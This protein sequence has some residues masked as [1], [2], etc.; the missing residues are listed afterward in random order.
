MCELS[1]CR[2]HQLMYRIVCMP[3]RPIPLCTVMLLDI[4]VAPG[5]EQPTRAVLKRRVHGLLGTALRGLPE[6]GRMAVES[7]SAAVVCFVGDPEEGLDAAVALRN[8]VEQRYDGKLSVRV[9]LNIGTVHVAMDP[10]NQLQVTGEGIHHA[11]EIKERA[12]PNEVVVSHRYHQLL[13]QLNPD[14]AGSFV[15]HAPGAAQRI[16]L[17][18]E[19]SSR[20]SATDAQAL[21]PP[22]PARSI[23]A[24]EV[25]VIEQEL[26]SHIGP[27]AS[28]LVRKV[29]PR[30]ANAQELRAILATAIPDPQV[31]RSFQ[32]QTN[33]QLQSQPAARVE[34][35][36]EVTRQ[37]DI[38]PAEFVVIEQT[39]RHFL[40][41]LAQPLIG[42][43][44]ERCHRMTDFVNALA[45]GIDAPP[46]R[47]AFL[48]ALQRA[49]PD[50]P[51]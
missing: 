38:S 3:E 40:G 33:V 25:Q 10:H 47:D 28:V 48:A 45:A 2:R 31:R 46:Q 4:A 17:Y 37:M 23:E 41:P 13:A 39:L 30:A 50:R 27:L 26:A 34:P 29:E 35:P 5:E 24:W 11:A 18:S 32:A 36:V 9:A 7:H 20:F 16:K 1:P 19:Q 12:L 42:R 43:E 6:T 15:D 21:M 49:L 51:S 14:R 22:A 8:Q 44:L